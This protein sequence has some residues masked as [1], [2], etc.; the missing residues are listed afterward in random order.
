[1]AKRKYSRIDDEHHVVRRCGYQVIERDILTNEV[2][3]LFPKVMMLRTE[4][5][6]PYLSVNM[7]E[8]C[9]GTK[10]EQLKAVV[11]IQRAKAIGKLSLQ[12]GVA[13]LKTGRI[14]EIGTRNSH[15]L[16]V[17]FTPKSDDPSYSRVS[18]LPLDN[19][20]KILIASLTVEAYQDF[21]LLADIDALP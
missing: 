16:V 13:I 7:L 8:H 15:R 11:A 19:S 17:R 6:E 18:G 1:M 12:S 5:D 21:M 4:T 9:D 14:L 20:D 10:I 3:G 2:V